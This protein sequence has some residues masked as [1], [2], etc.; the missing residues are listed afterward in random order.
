[1]PRRVAVLHMNQIGDYCFSLPLL[2][3]LRHALPDAHIV[4][5]MPRNL[6]ALATNGE[7]ADE[8]LPRDH[9]VGAWLGLL[10]AVRERRFDWFFVLPRSESAMA[11]AA[12]SGA[13]RRFGF[14]RPPWT[15]A[16]DDVETL[17]GHHGW[18]NYR[19]FLRRLDLPLWRDSYVGLLRADGPLP[20]GLPA[21]AFAVLSPGASARRECKT[22][23][24]RGFAE[25]MAEL[26]RR[27][28]LASL[29]VGSGENAAVNRLILQRL[30]ERSP[31]ARAAAMDLS[32]RLGLGSLAALLRRASLFVGIDSGVMHMAS[33]LDRPVVGIFGPTD[34]RWVAPQNEASRVVRRDDLPCI[35]CYM[36]GC[37]ERSCLDGLPPEA[38]LRACAELLDGEGTAPSRS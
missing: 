32:G 5:I 24:D 4:S 34:P 30:G 20:E 35:P 38:V 27:W 19:K 37:T 8:V 14:A 36:K 23:T 25:V 9:G 21:E 13:R 3:N 1:M 11:L 31:T 7:F 2:A 17:E 16:L 12:L 33:A 26:H 10:R 22:W 28:G 18:P 29:L 6:V 15:F